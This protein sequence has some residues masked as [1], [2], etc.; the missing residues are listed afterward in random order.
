MATPYRD[1]NPRDYRGKVLPKLSELK[2]RLDDIFDFVDSQYH[3]ILAD[4]ELLKN[5]DALSEQQ[6]QFLEDFRDKQITKRIFPQVMQI[7]QMLTRGITS[8]SVKRD[9]LHSLFNRPLSPDEIIRKFTQL[10]NSKLSG[11]DRTNARITL[12]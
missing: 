4:D 11:I 7:I 2:S 1:F 10:V 5:I 3:Q 12:E 6:V 8:V 9:E